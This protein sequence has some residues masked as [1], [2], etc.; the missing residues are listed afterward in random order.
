MAEQQTTVELLR[1]CINSLQFIT[2]KYDHQPSLTIVR[3]PAKPQRKYGEKKDINIQDK[4]N[5]RENE[6]YFD[7]K[8]LKKG[9][10]FH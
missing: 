7:G 3:Q 5:L 6:E 8:S 9:K 10:K 2:E 4:L 1:V